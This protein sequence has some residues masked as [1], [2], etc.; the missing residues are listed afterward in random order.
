VLTHG[1]GGEDFVLEYGVLILTFALAKKHLIL[2][3]I[4]YVMVRDTASKFK[5]LSGSTMGLTCHTAEM[6]T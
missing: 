4:I 6:K 1:L 5:C 2:I 3:L